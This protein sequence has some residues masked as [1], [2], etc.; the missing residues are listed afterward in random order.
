MASNIKSSFIFR[1]IK[2][3]LFL[4]VLILG[5]LIYARKDSSAQLIN[6]IF[7]TNISFVKMNSTIDLYI[8]NLLS[9][10]NI[11][12]FNKDETI[13]VN[14][15][16]SYLKTENNNYYITESNMIYGLFDGIVCKTENEDGKY[17]ITVFYKNEVTA[18]Y[19]E[20]TNINVTFQD[21]I[22]N[23]TILGSYD[24]SFK[25]LFEYNSNLISYEKALTI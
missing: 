13:R 11:F 17:N 25:V 2:T 16:S 6:N 20:L 21:K 8:N 22:D 14:N 7:N 12:G 1:L 24:K 18:C 9:N 23:N 3:V 19:Y 15:S 10:F 4:F 5:I